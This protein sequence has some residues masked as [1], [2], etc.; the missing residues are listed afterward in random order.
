[1]YNELRSIGVNLNQIAHKVNQ[2]E[3]HEP[4]FD[5]L[6]DTWITIKGMIK[7]LTNDRQSG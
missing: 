5:F 2:G 7:Q 6:M 4:H 3:S 1:M